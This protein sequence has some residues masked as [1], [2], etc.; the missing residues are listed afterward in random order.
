MSVGFPQAEPGQQQQGSWFS[1]MD[2]VSECS[3][4]LPVANAFTFQV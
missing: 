2:Q 4:V 3:L 1:L